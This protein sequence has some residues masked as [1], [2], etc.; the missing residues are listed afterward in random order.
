[1]KIFITGTDTGIGK[2]YTSCHILKKWNDRGLKTIAL[3]PISTGSQ[4]IEGAYINRDAH[5]LRQ[6]MSLHLSYSEV[7]PYCFKLPVSPHIAAEKEYVNLTVNEIVSHIRSIAKIKH[8]RMIIEGVGGLMVPLNKK[9]TQL[10]L[11]KALNYP[12]IF[13]VGLKL[14]CLNHT[15]LSI[16]MLK[17]YQIPIKGWL[18][19]HID[20]AF[21][22]V[23][24]NVETLK[25]YLKGIPFCGYL[26]YDES[27]PTSAKKAVSLIL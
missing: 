16:K 13:V 11:I 18:I 6:V 3:K 20:H 5:I 21:D 4:W 25:E 9:E 26:P 17:L 2:T 15:L 14:G 19:N 10:D 23:S 8:D 12:V 24:E 27:Y 22:C 7:N 1:M